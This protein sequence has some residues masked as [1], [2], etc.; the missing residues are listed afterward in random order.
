MPLDGNEARQLGDISRDKSIDR[1]ISRC[2]DGAA[3]LWEQ[4][5]IAVRERYSY[6]DSLKAVMKTWDAIEKGIQYLREIAV[7]EMLY[8]P[9]FVPNDPHQNH[10]PEGV[11]MMPDIWQKLTRTAPERYTPTLVAT[12]DRQTE[13]I[14][15]AVLPKHLRLVLHMI[16][17]Y[18]GEV[19]TRMAN[20]G[21]DLTWGRG[22]HRGA[23]HLAV[24]QEN[25]EMPFFF[26]FFF[27]FA[28]STPLRPGPALRADGARPIG[29][30]PGPGFHTRNAAARAGLSSG[31]ACPQE[32]F[33]P[34]C[35]AVGKGLGLG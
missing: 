15:A 32:G 18:D 12:F 34:R 30:A 29:A 27:N 9:N 24:G 23:Q 31:R 28:Y 1:G 13:G 21:G 8:D 16:H 4:M 20:E 7:V 17:A 14:S 11:R 3:T 33:I 22:P 10:D 35:R 6:K 19:S 26:F 25:A 5:L 2:L